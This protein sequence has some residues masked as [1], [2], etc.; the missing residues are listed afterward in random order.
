MRNNNQHIHIMVV[1]DE[2][3]V[4]RSLS[5]FLTIEGYAV[6]TAQNGKEALGLLKDFDADILISDIKMPELDG[7][8]LLKEM[9]S[10]NYNIPVVFMTGYGSIE[11]AV[12]AMKEGAYDYITKPIIDNEIKIVIDRLLKEKTIIEE[13]AQLKEKLAAT[14]RNSFHNILGEHDKMQK[15]YTLIEA[16]SNTRSTV[17]IRGESGTGKRMI[18][19][20]IHKYN[21]YERGKPFVEVSCGALT[22]TLLESELFGHVKGSFTGAIKDKIGRFELADGGTIF[23]DEIDAFSPALQVK[24]L[25]VLQDGELERVG[26]NTTKKVDVR[27][28]AA[29]NQGLEKLIEQG[30][31]RQDLYYRLNIISMEIPPL[32]DRKSDIPLLI[33]SFIEKHAAHSKRRVKEITKDAVELLMKYDWPGNVRELENIIERAVILSKGEYITPQDLPECIFGIKESNNAAAP[34]CDDGNGNGFKL[35]DALKE[36]ERDLLV[37]AL[38]SVNWNRNEAAGVLGINRTTLYKKMVRYGLLSKNGKKN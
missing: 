15:I 34:S 24:L 28:I 8:R 23:L 29:T 19:H 38:N 32:R 14:R 4:R 17:L 10:R 30:K 27:V 20:A 35:K 1:D 31:F 25:R 33:Q 9:K 6:S 13:N 36:P 22:E 7:I 21:E 2:P 16:I 26:D 3:L 11:N 5:E 18:A 37:K 12:D